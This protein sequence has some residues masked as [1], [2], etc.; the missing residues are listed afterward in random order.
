MSNEVA[1]ILFPNGK[2]Y[3]TGYSSTC[4]AINHIIFEDKAQIFIDAFADP[5]EEFF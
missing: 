5:E 1:C 4:D 3:F 2:G